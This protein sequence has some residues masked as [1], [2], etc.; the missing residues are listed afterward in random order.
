MKWLFPAEFR[1]GGTR[2]ASMAARK[3]AGWISGAADKTETPRAFQLNMP[4][5]ADFV[6]AE[7]APIHGRR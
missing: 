3:R 5:A 4:E 6:V 7:P 1:H 2:V